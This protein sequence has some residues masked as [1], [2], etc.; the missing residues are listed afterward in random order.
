MLLEVLY[1]LIQLSRVKMARRHSNELKHLKFN[2]E[3]HFFHNIQFDLLFFNSI[4]LLDALLYS[5]EDQRIIV[6]VPLLL[7]DEHSNFC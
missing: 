3:I 4:H 5:F 1:L 6:E 2:D 7:F